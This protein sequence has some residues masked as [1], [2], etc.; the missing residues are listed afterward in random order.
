MEICTP[1]FWKARL[2]VHGTGEYPEA[3]A[4]QRADVEETRRLKAT[5]CQPRRGGGPGQEQGQGGENS[6]RGQ[7]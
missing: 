3:G 5:A 1:P 2:T 4:G 6:A 7:N